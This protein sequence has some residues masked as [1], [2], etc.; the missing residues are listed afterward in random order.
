MGQSTM[1]GLVQIWCWLTMIYMCFILTSLRRLF[2]LSPQCHLCGKQM[3]LSR[4]VFRRWVQL[5]R[6]GR[7]FQPWFK[8]LSFIGD[9]YQSPRQ[10]FMLLSGWLWRR[11]L[12]LCNNHFAWWMCAK[13]W[14]AQLPRSVFESHSLGSI[15]AKHFLRVG[16]Q[17]WL[18]KNW[19]VP[20]YRPW[21]G[22]YARNL[23]PCGQMQHSSLDVAKWIAP[24]HK[25]WNSHP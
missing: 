24:H 5:L 2:W 21:W 20:I 22:T 17:L 11:R 19:V 9:M 16:K 6:C 13:Q 8:S 23:P 10:L 3:C 14:V 12:P 15:L 7:M 18:K 25:W 4:W 1:G